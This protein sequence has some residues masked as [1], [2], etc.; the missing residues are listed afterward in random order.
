MTD[1]TSA[2]TLGHLDSGADTSFTRE[3]PLRRVA[4]EPIMPLTVMRI[5]V[6]DVAHTKVGAGVRDHS[7]FRQLPI[8]R[9]WG[10]SD[11]GLRLVFGDAETARA[12]ARQVYRFH[13]HVNGE[14]GDPHAAW[15]EDEAYTAHDASLLLWVWATLVDSLEVTFTRWVRPFRPGEADAF[16]RDMR[17]WARFFGIPEELLP[18]D[19][20]AF[21]AYL[22]R[23]IG[24]PELAPTSTGRSQ[25]EDVLWYRHWIV[26]GPVV[27]LFRIMAIG[28]LDP[29]LR[30]RLDLALDDHDQRLFDRVD[31]LLARWYPRLPAARTQLPYLYLLVRRP[32]IGLEA[33]LRGFW[34]QIRR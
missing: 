19:R 1:T 31:D 14:L 15:P 28:T 33:R 4:A 29:G 16:Y 7:R 27:R 21:A 6:M 12:A 17:T 11:A 25:I 24:G 34:R 9:F 22:D 5:L 30:E 2:P 10:T 26:P 3:S 8:R 20:A 18:A 13:D 32:T 23:M